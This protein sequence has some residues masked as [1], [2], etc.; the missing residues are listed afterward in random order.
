MRETIETGDLVKVSCKAG[1][2]TVVAARAR[3]LEPKY[4][5]QIGD[6]PTTAQW[7]NSDSVTLM[8]KTPK[9]EPEPEPT[10]QAVSQ[11]EPETEP[12]P[13][14]APDYSEYSWMICLS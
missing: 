9:T 3:N 12:V 4:F 5:V 13:Q 10:F 11:P 1:L 7:F 6:D 14:S 8:L 2:W